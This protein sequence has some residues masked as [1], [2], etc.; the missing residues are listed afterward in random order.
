LTKS[1]VFRHSIWVGVMN[2]AVKDTNTQD[3]Q[4]IDS[5][6][7]RDYPDDKGGLILDFSGFASDQTCDNGNQ[8]LGYFEYP[9]NDRFYAGEDKKEIYERR[10]NIARPKL[11]AEF[12]ERDFGDE[13]DFTC[14]GMTI[15]RAGEMH[16]SLPEVFDF[17][18]SNVLTVAKNVFDECGQER[19]ESA[20]MVMIIQRNDIKAG[21]SHRSHVYAGNWHDHVS[22]DETSDLVYL[23]SN[24][25]GTD[26][27]D[28]KGG[29]INTPDN[30]LSRIGGE[31]L[32][33]SQQNTTDNI[34]RREWTGIT[35]S[36]MPVKFTRNSQYLCDNPA[37]ITTDNPKFGEYK[38][39]AQEYLDNSSGFHVFEEPVDLIDEYSPE[40]S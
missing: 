11:I 24:I 36:F 23:A 38:E 18:L 19:F 9:L 33:K 37:L 27:K 21:D 22:G 6:Y 40:L 31:W 39:K 26:I 3:R 30:S 16:I 8:F 25:L 28:G 15:K 7:F 14:S 20:N 34:I 12:D 5:A 17:A 4:V 35:V 29:V 32:H 2:M 13:P 10:N 1:Y